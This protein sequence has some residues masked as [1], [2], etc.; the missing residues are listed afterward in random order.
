M[1]KGKWTYGVKEDVNTTVQEVDDLRL[2]RDA[3][4]IGSCER[5][6]DGLATH[7]EL[8][9]VGRNAKGPPDMLHVKVI[10]DQCS[11]GVTKVIDVAG[12]SD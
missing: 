6:C 8:L 9:D 4:V 5:L 12:R 1:V 3:Q 7:Y 10:L 11:V 2:S